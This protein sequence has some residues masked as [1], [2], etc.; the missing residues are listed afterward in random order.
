MKESCSEVDFED[1]LERFVR[2]YDKRQKFYIRE[3]DFFARLGESLGYLTFFHDRG[4]DLR[5]Q[6]EVPMDLAWYARKQEAEHFRIVLRIETGKLFL[7]SYNK[8]ANKIL[9]SSKSGHVPPNLIAIVHSEQENTAWEFIKLLN[10]N[11][12]MPTKSL[13]L[14]KIFNF[15]KNFFHKILCWQLPFEEST[16]PR[17]VLTDTGIT[18]LISLYFKDQLGYYKLNLNPSVKVL[19]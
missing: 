13:I 9:A 10:R 2:C 18:G 6:R 15:D 7:K 8:L 19:L 4:L 12:A 14:C 11:Y 1:I 3:V 17:T 5:Y 16:V